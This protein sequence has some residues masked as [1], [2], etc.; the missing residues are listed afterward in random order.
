MTNLRFLICNSS[1]TNSD[2]LKL[3]MCYSQYFFIAGNQKYLGF[4]GLASSFYL[5]QMTLKEFVFYSM[6]KSKNVLLILFVL[7]S[8]RSFSQ[9]NKP[10]LQLFLKRIVK[11]KYTSFVPEFIQQENGKDVFELESRKGK[12]ILRGSNGISIASALNYYLKNYCHS[13]LTWNGNNLNLPDKLPVVSAAIRKTTPYQYRY[14][15]NYCTF[16][17]SMA[18]WNWDRW[19]Q[20]IDWM[21]MN[22]INMPLA[23][24]GEEAIWQEVYHNMG[25][26]DN[27]LN[28]FFTGPAY[29]SWLWM[30]NIDGWGGALP[31]HW[32]ESHLEL[33]KKIVQ[34]ERAMGMKTV[35][36]AFTGHVP[37]TFK[38]RF[39][40]AKVKRT[41]WDAG[42]GDV[43]ILDPLDP[44]FEEIG[45]KYLEA[46]TKVFGTDHFYSADTF[47]EN[48]PPTSDSSYLDQM[49]KKVFSSMTSADPKAIWVMQGW[50]FH[51]NASFW[52]PAQIQGLL[53]A[54]PD[55]H[56]I[57]LD[58]YSESHPV[59]NRTNSYY[60]KPWIWNL[61]SNFGGNI[62]MWGRMKHVAEDPSAALHDP[63]SGKM[64]GIGLTP[65]GIEQ[66]PALYQLMLENVWQN[67][68]VDLPNWLNQYTLQRYNTY[69]ADVNQAWEILSKTVYNGG[70][71]E[72]GPE[73]IIV[74]RPTINSWSDRVRTKLDYNA[75]DLVPAWSL[76]VK[77]SA[78]LQQSDGFQ[79]DLVDI[80]RQVLANYAITLQQKWVGAYLMH[81]TTAYTLYTNKFLELMDDI[82]LVLSTRK[83]FMLG[84][85]IEDARA[86]GISD[87]EKNL[88]EKNA[89]DLITLWGDQESELHEYANRQWAGLIKDFYR[90]R[91]EK[92]FKYLHV[93]MIHGER[94]E[95][96]DFEKEIKAW[97]WSWVIDHSVKY[98]TIPTGNPIE[99]SVGLFKKYESEILKTN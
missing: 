33:Q 2:L 62:S 98:S 6:K 21:A 53:K 76:F 22:G 93:K 19:Q 57:V 41:N 10:E 92:Y 38:D 78:V 80:T 27:E 3:G 56:M 60:G 74:A 63:A 14:Y 26:T 83:D 54:V 55:D 34:A 71:G 15:L 69:N 95:T 82:D 90:P 18:W 1:K 77:S 12:I 11:E 39:P 4:V 23:L 32:K 7:G 31:A 44:M 35:L 85:W 40:N 36:P 72:G 52:K 47:N 16:Q 61:L 13:L 89:R 45:K 9:L 51:Y 88:Y 43:Y 37:P 97:E 96:N 87:D 65:E 5:R 20:E 46:Q 99:I 48:V 42:F 75:K 86:N 28:Q 66:N 50:M 79:Y 59:W 24:T 81:D 49:S 94:M 67:Q 84:K 25:F 64:M 29:F 58:L 91:W 17:Y 8:L 73:S 70:L 68:S 30:G